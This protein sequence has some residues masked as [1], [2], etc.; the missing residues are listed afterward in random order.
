MVTAL[1]VLDQIINFLDD[2]IEQF[3]DSPQPKRLPV[4]VLSG[5]LGSGKVPSSYSSEAKISK[6]KTEFS[7]FKKL[8]NVFS[9]NAD[10]KLNLSGK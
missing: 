9:C 7:I 8:K 5:F 10:L 6:S 2:K 3:P 1:D 4:T